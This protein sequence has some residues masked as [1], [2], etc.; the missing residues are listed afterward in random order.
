[1]PGVFKVFFPFMALLFSVGQADELAVST[2]GGGYGDVYSQKILQPF[3]REREVQ[4]HH[5]PLADVLA[6]STDK[7]STIDAIEVSLHEAMSGCQSG[8][9]MLL[10]PSSVGAFSDIRSFLPN[11]VQPC[12]VG[13][14]LWGTLVAYAPD[15][16]LIHI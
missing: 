16:S 2:W 9:L 4:I 8:E 1:M 5:V 12:A 6:D 14:W 13:Q 3:S 10:P 11:S 15:L 7:Q